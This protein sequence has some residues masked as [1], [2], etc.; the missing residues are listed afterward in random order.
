LLD[1][2]LAERRR[3]HGGRHLGGRVSTDARKRGDHQGDSDAGG[4]YGSGHGD[5]E[6]APHRSSRRDRL[7]RTGVERAVQLAQTGCWGLDRRWRG[8]GT[9]ELGEQFVVG[10]GCAGPR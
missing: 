10:H 5:R 4:R 3:R 6:Q 7:R 1:G 9:G 8:K 2:R